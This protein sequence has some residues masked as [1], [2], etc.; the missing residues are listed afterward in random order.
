VA[1]I[2]FQFINK[3]RSPAFDW[4][5]RLTY[6]FLYTACF[7]RKNISCIVGQNFIWKS[8][9]KVMLKKQKGIFFYFNV[10]HFLPTKC[11]LL[12]TYVC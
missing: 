12:L 3:Q 5:H 4:E 7:V 11:T 8:F 1:L 9:I 6:I 10:L 2:A